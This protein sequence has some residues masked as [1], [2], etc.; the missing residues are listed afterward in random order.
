MMGWLAINWLT[1]TIGYAAAR[2]QDPQ[3]QGSGDVPAKCELMPP[4]ERPN[5]SI[6]LNGEDPQA[7]VTLP[8][9]AKQLGERFLLDQ[10]EIWTSPVRLRWPDANWLL[11]LGGVTAGMFVT[12][13]EMSRHISHNPTTISHYN[14]LSNVAVAGLLGGA[15]AMWLLS[16]PKHE[17]HWRE[18][19]F[20]AGEAVVNSLV[21]AEAMK[22]PLG[23]QR[24]NEGNGNGEFFHGGF[25]FPSEHAAAAW[26]VAGVVAHEYPGPLTKILVYSLATLVDY[27][28]Y[29]ARQHFPSDVFI[30]SVIGNL[31][32]ENVYNQHH[33][34][35][36]GGSSWDPFRNFLRETRATSSANMGS[37]YV[38]LDSW[39]YPAMDGLI[40]QGYV[41]SAIVGMRPWTRFECARLINEAGEEL[42]NADA[43]TS[44]PARIYRSLAEEFS[45]DRKLMEG[46]ENTRARME[47]VYTR[48]SGIS[49]EP[50]SQGYYYDF[51]QT[52]INDFGRPYEQGFNNVTGF[53]GWATESRFSVYA[54][55]EFQHAAGAPPLSA[56]ARQ[57]ISQ[58]QFVP[59]PPA[60]P[61]SQIDRF[62]LLDT[63]V[64][65]TLENWQ[66]TFGKQSLWWGPGAGGP[67]MFSN[68]APPIN[69]FRVNRV[70]PFKLPSVLG[71]MGP[72]RVEFFLGQLS[73]QN[74]VFGVG[75]GLLGSWTTPFSPQPMISGERFSFKPTPNVE[76]GFSATDIFAGQGVPFTLH[77][78][79]RGVF[80]FAG[81]GNQGQ[82][83]SSLDP[84]DGRSGFDLAYR[85]PFLRNW[86]TFYA[87]GFTDDQI[88]PVAYW[89]RS[90]WTAG[91]YFSHL[92]KAPKLDLR[93]EG[94][95]TDLPIGG[96]VGRG[97]FYY[98]VR[99]RSGYTNQE[100]LMGSWIGRDGQGVQAWS[101]Y[102]FSPKNR[103]QVNFRHEKVS[104]QFLPGG[105]TLTDFAI[106]GDLW[107]S[108]RWA[109][110]AN[111]QY[112]SWIFPSIQPGR[113]T[114]FATSLQ[115][116]FRPGPLR[117]QSM[118]H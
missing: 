111:G 116:T 89:D 74:F 3:E 87:D 99:Y 92:P 45:E 71:F 54:S 32:A 63:Y 36:L 21:V 27:S 106:R 16:Y 20:L 90:A 1:G 44:Q 47:S 114:N 77:T 76:F 49:G 58:V 7:S 34:V 28:R 115:L 91:L 43:S 81:H 15:G 103:I 14:T 86:A 29:R 13:A 118:I 80:R 102:W 113:Q 68:N 94:V 24:P 37:P 18:T 88:S 66:I 78:Y 104:Q 84:G 93:V 52:V 46:G 11:P 109:I 17:P 25:S 108:P 2:P 59:E 100:Y 85:L 69:M 50:L 6:K 97:F 95:Y 110:S 41:R 117:M 19:G 72:M 39:V 4:E 75:T 40:A 65:M 22:Y 67:M 42:D 98:N 73:D 26:A 9:N 82:P 57:V 33:D 35:E 48:L 31:V 60:T 107:T 56:A 10:E 64:G 70:S 62:Q 112:E 101:N 96:A 55:G 12:D 51:G 23:R 5:A 53:S 30:G 38:P 8:H 79:L 61:I 105:G 83:G